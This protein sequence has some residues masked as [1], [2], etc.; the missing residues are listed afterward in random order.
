[1]S[2]ATGVFLVLAGLG[3]AALVLPA[4]D[5]DAERQLSDIVRLALGPQGATEPRN[6]G[7]GIPSP[8]VAATAVAPAAL[9]RAIPKPATASSTVVTGSIEPVER[10][11]TSPGPKL[12]VTSSSATNSQAS[13]S[14]SLAEL[15]KAIQGEL[16]RVGCYGGEV[17]G[18]WSDPTRKAMREFVE[19]VNATLPVD[20]PDH[21]LKMLVQ[22]HPGNACA[23][24]SCPSG[25]KLSA[26]G[27]CLPNAI[28]A[29][30]PA[31]LPRRAAT[32]QATEQVV[33][34]PATS[35][36]S[37]VSTVARAEG[38]TNV[39]LAAPAT[40]AWSTTVAEVK[41]LPT[42]APAPLPGRMSVGAPRP[43]A[44]DQRPQPGPALSS[45]EPSPSPTDHRPPQRT[46]VADNG[47]TAREAAATKRV[48]KSKR[49][50][51]IARADGPGAPPA[52][53]PA[54]PI[55]YSYGSAYYSSAPL[56]RRFGVHIF[57]DQRWGR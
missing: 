15:T 1:M 42:V 46:D 48:A 14:A 45:S 57:A 44:S 51:R 53:R 24:A 38:P 9:P 47:D 27:R 49:Q 16:R 18:E 31:Q 7:T 52:Y 22:G 30:K 19:R 56:P 34:K 11:P 55:R 21:I 50:R 54:P 2:K 43:S 39:P 12:L 41:D 8:G 33:S 29:Q 32:Q 26:A 3:T 6:E 35:D 13:G 5:R 10:K 20:Q 40:S 23:Q 17:N 25:Q 28:V 36:A 4:V 37:A